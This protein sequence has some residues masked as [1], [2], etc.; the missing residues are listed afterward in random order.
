MPY[1][2]E[3]GD[4]SMALSGDAMLTQSLRVFQEPEFLKI[5]EIQNEAD[6]A[7]TNLEMTYHLHTEGTPQP[8]TEWTP[9]CA[10]PKYLEDLKWFG[11]DAVSCANNHAFDYGEGGML[12]N[13]RNL[14][15]YDIPFSG[16]GRNLDEAR[17]PCYV[18]TAQGRVALISCTSSFLFQSRAGSAGP[19]IPGRP[20]V[21]Y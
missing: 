17:M 5:R 18:D 7:L 14:E 2:S 10:H 12:A 13:M 19:T 3:K 20:G 11:I 16:S 21:S 15:G 4:I 9:T 8:E 1:F 6:V